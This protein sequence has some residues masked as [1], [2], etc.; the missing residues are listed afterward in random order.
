MKLIP[1]GRGLV[2]KI[3][4]A[5]WDSVI[6]HRWFACK[7][8]HKTLP[9]TWYAAATVKDGSGKGRTVSM[10]QFLM[11]PPAGMAVD[12]QDHDGLNNQR[13]NLRL[14]TA[15]EN[16]INRRYKPGPLPRGVFKVKGRDTYGAQIRKN[17]VKYYGGFC[18]KTPQEAAHA[19]NRLAIE[20]HGDFAVLNPF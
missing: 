18:H 14:C 12:H 15:S 2:A 7:N 19:Y 17:G 13:S 6:Q 5:D 16:Q 3:D 10:H 8:D 20:H 9:A 11:K 4:D 1:L